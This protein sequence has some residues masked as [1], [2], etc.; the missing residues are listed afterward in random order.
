MLPGAC[1]YPPVHVLG[2]DHEYA[3]G[4]YE[5]V[6]DLR[7]RSPKWQQKPFSAL[8]ELCIGFGLESGLLNDLESGR[9]P[10]RSPVEAHYAAMRNCR[11]VAAR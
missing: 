5:D 6:I 11:S 9:L 2:L 4:R 1:E 8:V 7:R 3:T 10:V